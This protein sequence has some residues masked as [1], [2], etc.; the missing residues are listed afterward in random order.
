MKTFVRM[1]LPL[2]SFPSSFFSFRGP[3]PALLKAWAPAGPCKAD[4]ERFCKDEAHGMAETTQWHGQSQERALSGHVPSSSKSAS[5]LARGI[6]TNFARSSE[7]DPSKVMGCLRD[8]VSQL[9]PGC[10]KTK[11]HGIDGAK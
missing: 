11:G 9:S 4:F 6:S 2:A 10:R 7:G 3:W 1:L 8:H 5:R